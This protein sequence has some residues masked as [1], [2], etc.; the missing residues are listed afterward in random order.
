MSFEPGNGLEDLAGSAGLA[1]ADEV[2]A[3]VWGGAT[4][5]EVWPE[6]WGETMVRIANMVSGMRFK[7]NRSL[8]AF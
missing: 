5:A 7:T 3:S 4:A 1:L 6:E 8:M 2:L